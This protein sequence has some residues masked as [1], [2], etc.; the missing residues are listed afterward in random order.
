MKTKPK[1]ITLTTVEAQHILHLIEQ[2][3]RTGEYTA[4]RWQYWL[5]SARIKE[6]LK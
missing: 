1:K 5:R 3:E 2:N 6:K 4:P